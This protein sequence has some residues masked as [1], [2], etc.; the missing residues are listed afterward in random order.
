MEIVKWNDLKAMYES[1]GKHQYFTIII[2]REQSLRALILDFQHSRFHDVVSAL[3]VGKYWRLICA[4]T[5][6][7]QY[8]DICA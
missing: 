8:L 4:V 7:S 5:Y 3:G 1:I 2:N 6:H